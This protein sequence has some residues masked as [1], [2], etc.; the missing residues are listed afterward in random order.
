MR[1][2]AGQFRGRNLVAPEG[3]TTR[4]ILDRVKVALFDWLGSL[5]DI[6]GSLPPVDV[7]DVFCG[8]GSLGI[9]SL[10]RGASSCTFVEIDREAL[11][12]LREN[13]TNLRIGDNGIVCETPAQSLR[14]DIKPG[15]Q[16]GLIFLDPPYPLSEKTGPG[17]IM[18]QVFERLGT[19]L[20]VS[21]DV[22]LVWRH[23]SRTIVPDNM[24]VAWRK[25]EARTWG[26]MTISL[27][28]RGVEASA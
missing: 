8:G 19:R 12:C 14:A 11:R 27:Y 25:D 5:L 1:V 2:I 10:S 22:V 9:E 28:R 23:D 4:P 16:F 24:A 6:P 21:D 13:L 17:T 20:P 3:L 7:L 15:V 26:H 18:T